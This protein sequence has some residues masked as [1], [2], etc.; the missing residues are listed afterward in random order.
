MTSSEWSTPFD[1][2]DDEECLNSLEDLEEGIIKT[3][4]N[5]SNEYTIL[6]VGETGTGKTTFLSL[7][8]NILTGRSPNDYVFSHDEDNEAGDGDRHSQTNSA[9]LY[10]FKS[11]NGVAVRILDT[12]GLA[13]TRGLAQDEKHKENIARAIKDNI[14]VVNAVLIL[15]NGTLPRLSAATDYALST[16]SS[17]FPRSLVE[18]IGII[19]TNVS[20]QLSLNFDQNSLP[21]RL[22]NPDS[23]FR[24]DNPVALWK[25][26]L[27]RC[28]NS[29]VTK[30]ERSEWKAEI[31]QKHQKALRTLASLFDWLDTLVPQ[32]TTDIVRLYG[33]TQ[34][35]EQKIFH[36]LA[37]AG[38]LTIKETELKRII[39]DLD[40]TKSSKEKHQHYQRIIKNKIWVQYPTPT[41]SATC[42]QSDCYS[43]C[44]IRQSDVVNAK[45]SSA[46][47]CLTLAFLGLGLASGVMWP[48]ALTWGFSAFYYPIKFLAD[49]T[50]PHCKHPYHNHHYGAMKWQQEEDKKVLLDQEAL[51]NYTAA[52]TEHDRQELLRVSVEQTVEILQKEIDNSLSQVEALTQEYAALSISGSF[53]EQVVKTIV[54]LELHLESM[55]QKGN[56]ES[57]RKVDDSLKKMKNMLE[58]VEKAQT[59]ANDQELE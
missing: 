42:L 36:Y 40:V 11:K 46:P 38:Q 29:R 5:T 48:F 4:K 49:S 51:R 45:I 32:P 2:D 33:K 30:R 47:Q 55:R 31:H 52:K 53:S 34:E 21:E 19:F 6:L 25:K 28:S 57:A 35:I 8:A 26:C 59:K 54:L 50:C 12:P 39:K 1:D 22:R 24:L 43:N 44:P 58:V 27:A 10:E 41:G 15:A 18:N 23:Q 7:L 3:Q 37:H 20:I 17:I 16:L 13:D 9:K 14:H 56:V